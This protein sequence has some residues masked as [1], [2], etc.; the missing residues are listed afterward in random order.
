[1]KWG[2]WAC[3]TP[4]VSFSPGSNIRLEAAIMAVVEPKVTVLVEEG[5]HPRAMRDGDEV[6]IL[7]IGSADIRFAV[8]RSDVKRWMGELG[9]AIR[10]V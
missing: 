10:G 8:G 7:P 3:R 5:D 4:C 2:W 6:V 1:M 9:K